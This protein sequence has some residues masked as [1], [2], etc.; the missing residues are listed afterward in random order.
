[1]HKKL[2]TVK[3]CKKT[4]KAKQIKALSVFMRY[5]RQIPIMR[6]F[7]QNDEILIFTTISWFFTWRGTQ[8]MVEYLWQKFKNTCNLN[9]YRLFWISAIWL[10]IFLG[11][12]KIC[13]FIAQSKMRLV[14]QKLRRFCYPKR[15]IIIERKKSYEDY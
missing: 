1:M 4:D 9:A 15:H 11:K 2:K 8:D 10:P 12:H 5:F 3:I 13:I 14:I 6:V 7:V